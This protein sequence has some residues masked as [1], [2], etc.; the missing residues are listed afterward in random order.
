MLLGT[1]RVGEDF[2]F[3]GTVC[4]VS[5]RERCVGASLRRLDVDGSIWVGV[6]SPSL[7]LFLAFLSGRVFS[8]VHG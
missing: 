5:K 4:H 2:G 7:V 6:L 8:G 1:E 3:G